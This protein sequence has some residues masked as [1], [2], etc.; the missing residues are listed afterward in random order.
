MTSAHLSANRAIIFFAWKLNTVHLLSQTNS[1]TTLIHQPR[2]QPGR[3]GIQQPDKL[4]FKF[5][6]HELAVNGSG[7]KMT[8]QMIRDRQDAPIWN[9]IEASNY[10]QALKLVDKRLA[11]KSTDYLEVSLP[12]LLSL[13]TNSLPAPWR[14][15]RHVMDINEFFPYRQ[16]LTRCNRLLKSLFG[17]DHR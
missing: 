16:M 14:I 10:K 15:Y 11:K 17:R 12:R 8:D 5:T 9:A 4:D 7:R 1:F 2:P 3:V 13:N 6:P